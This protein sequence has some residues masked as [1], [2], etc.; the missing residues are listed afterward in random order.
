[1]LILPALLPIMTQV[2][3][4]GFTELGF[5]I[6]AYSFA[7]GIVQAPVGFLI[8]KFGARRF[9]IVALFGTAA[10]FTGIGLSD[11]YAALVVLMVFAGLANSVFHP[12]DYS[13]LNASVPEHVIG[14]AFSLHSFFAQLGNAAGPMTVLALLT[15]MDFS[16]A[17]LFCGGAGIVAA[18]VLAA[19]SGVLK[20][21]R[22]PAPSSKTATGPTLGIGLLLSAP[23]M[24]GFAFF[25]LTA[26]NH[27]GVTGFGA[28]SVH[29]LH[30][31]DLTDAGIALGAYLLS[32]P[33][34]VLTGGWLADK[35]ARH[36]HVAV[37]M[38]AIIAA[39]LFAI[40]SVSITAFAAAGLFAVIG[41]CQGVATPSRDMLI[42]AAT[43]PQEM[44]KVFGFV[45]S[46]LNLAGVVTPPVL[47]YLLDTGSPGG[48][49]WLLFG[50]ALCTLSVA[51][52]TRTPRQPRT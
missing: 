35:T 1:M 36:A 12:A 20:E 14:R 10:A 30:D 27:R 22:A 26:V 32:T 34:G 42:R 9:L 21:S 13:I 24:L 31:I 4:V 44:G 18:A 33:F 40:A 46:G 45:S 37:S 28:A 23:I 3:D 48:V 25:A 16:T 15:V 5:A 6:T 19:N 2:Y 7:T 29:L 17:M 51:A 11:S 43:P 39:A 50:V 8:D 52:I 47:G 49:F 41:F 38:F